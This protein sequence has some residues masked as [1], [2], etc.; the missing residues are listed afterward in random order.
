MEEIFKY[1]FLVALYIA[2][3]MEFKNEEL[4]EREMEIAKHLVQDFSLNQIAEKTGINKKLLM[5]HMRN[6]MKKLNAE[7]MSTLIKILKEKLNQL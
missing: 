4:I 1:G 3:M 5:V 7:N 6:M 2:D